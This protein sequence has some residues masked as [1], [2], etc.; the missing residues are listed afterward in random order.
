[1]SETRLQVVREGVEV[2]EVG[3]LVAKINYDFVDEVVLVDSVVRIST[4][5]QS[6]I[7]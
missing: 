4:F 7:D 3:M 6:L 1:M 2:L 5:H